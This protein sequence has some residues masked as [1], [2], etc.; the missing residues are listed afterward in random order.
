M[1]IGW[2]TITLPNGTKLKIPIWAAIRWPRLPK[3]W[4]VVDGPDGGLVTRPG[5]KPQPQ[6]WVRRP[7]LGSAVAD[8]ALDDLVVLGNL[9]ELAKHLHDPA[10]TDRLQDVVADLADSVAGN[11]P[12]EAAVV[13]V[14]P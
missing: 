4:E 10:I 13:T 3:K 11:I 1:I 2:Y 7:D 6:P 8:H 12:R 5:Q 14:R 9:H